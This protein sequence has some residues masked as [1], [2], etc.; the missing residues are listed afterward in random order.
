MSSTRFAESMSRRCESRTS[1]V[2]KSKGSIQQDGVVVYNALQLQ[3][4]IGGKKLLFEFEKKTSGEYSEV[5][6]MQNAKW[7]IF[8]TN[9]QMVVILEY[10]K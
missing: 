8:G 7:C 2:S 4:I 3:L 9:R 1:N 10:Y 5:E 6:N